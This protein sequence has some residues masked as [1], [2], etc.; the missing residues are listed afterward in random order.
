MA[1]ATQARANSAHSLHTQGHRHAFHKP[2]TSIGAAGHWVRTAGILAPLVIGE[3]IKDPETKWR[4]IRIAAVTTALVSEGM[5]T[6]KIR[7]ERKERAE[8]QELAA[9]L[10]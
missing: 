4:A 10:V 7:N 1:Y 6:H 9:C 5:W 3:F 8:E 2:H